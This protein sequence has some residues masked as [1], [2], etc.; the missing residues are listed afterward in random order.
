MPVKERVN[1]Y[2][3]EVVACLKRKYG[4]EYSPPIY[5]R[6][7]PM[8]TD[9]GDL[10]GIAAIQLVECLISSGVLEWAYYETED[11]SRIDFRTNNQKDENK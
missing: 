8:E 10:K 4:D 6:C 7:I 1:I 3:M 5:K 9:K 2:K 11:G